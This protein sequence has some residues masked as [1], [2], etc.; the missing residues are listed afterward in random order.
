MLL[1]W[2]SV[3]VCVGQDGVEIKPCLIKR[4]CIG[5]LPAID[6]SFQLLHHCSSMECLS[7]NP[8]IAAIITGRLTAEHYKVFAQ[9]ELGLFT[10]TLPNHGNWAQISYGT[11]GHKL[12]AFYFFVNMM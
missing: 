9:Q 10:T 7:L 3:C 6:T 2:E 5:E 1:M 12:Q 11:K 8:I 4:F